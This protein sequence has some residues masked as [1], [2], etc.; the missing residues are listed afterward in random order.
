MAVFRLQA[1]CLVVTGVAAVSPGDAEERMRRSKAHAGKPV[2]EAQCTDHT[3]ASCLALCVV[4]KEMVNA[5]TAG[6]LDASPVRR[7]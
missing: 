7:V 5:W 6:L 1:S 3:Q 2:W 4:E